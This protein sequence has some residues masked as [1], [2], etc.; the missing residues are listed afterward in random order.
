MAKSNRDNFPDHVRE[1][2]AQ[3]VAYKCSRPGCERVTSGPHSDPRKSLKLGVA[4]HIIA[5]AARGP[6]ASADISSDDRKSI[7]NA[8]WLCTE[9]STLID[10]DESRYP[11]EELR[12]WK[13]EA[14]EAARL[15][16]ER[17]LVDPVS[18]L[19]NPQAFPPHLDVF[20]P[21]TLREAFTGR[22]RQRQSL[23]RWW[24]EDGPPVRVLVGMGGMGKSSLAWVWMH[25]DVLGNRVI[26][27]SATQEQR[28]RGTGL[29]ASERPEG[30][31]WWSFYAPELQIQKSFE[32]FLDRALG[33][34]SGGQIR[35]EN[36][37]SLNEK[38]DV[39]LDRLRSRRFLIILDGFERATKLYDQLTAPYEADLLEREPTSELKRCSDDRAGR[40]L[41][42]AAATSR[43]RV[44]ITSRVHPAD[45]DGL[46]N[47]E[48]HDLEALDPEDSLE[49]FRA[50]RVS[51]SDS[52]I[53]AACSAAGHHPLAVRLMIGYIM[54]TPGQYRGHI[55]ALPETPLDLTPDDRRRHIFE[56]AYNGLG[57]QD[58]EFFSRVAVY[59][60]ATAYHV[61]QACSPFSSSDELDRAIE[62]LEQ[63]GFLSYDREHSTYDMHP[64]VRQY[65]Y[66]QMATTERRQ[67]AREAYA[68]LADRLSEHETTLATLS[69]T[70]EVFGHAMEGGLLESAIKIF[71]H[72]L[73]PILFFRIGHFRALADLLE[74][75]IAR[76]REEQPE[77]VS[78]GNLRALMDRLS[79][80]YNLSGFPR[81]GYR[82]ATEAAT[83]HASDPNAGSEAKRLVYRASSAMR[84]GELQLAT[85]ALEKSILINQQ[86]G[87]RFAET[88]ARLNLGLA[89]TWSARFEEARNHL[90]AAAE[91]MGDTPK[92]RHWRCI[93][94]VHHARAALLMGHGDR[95]L[96][97]ARAAHKIATDGKDETDLVR[98]K[99]V[100][101]ASLVRRVE[102]D[103]A[104]RP[105]YL[106]MAEPHLLSALRTCSE[107]EYGELMM[108][109]HI[110]LA[111][112]HFANGDPAQAQQ[113]AQSARALA[114]EGGHALKKA[115]ADEILLELA[116]LAAAGSIQCGEAAESVN[117]RQADQLLA[118]WSLS[119]MPHVISVEPDPRS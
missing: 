84:L 20:H 65:A 104:L 100:L 26:E 2:V 44:L 15:E 43:S 102:E 70:R 45:V 109:L 73:Y 23:T 10:K 30:V 79:T 60:Q 92:S 115:E 113:A 50:H 9:C 6:R 94:L 31:L 66:T 37:P 64:L 27:R 33:Y 68:Y 38:I 114:Q 75:L 77:Q 19:Q 53:L 119:S 5:A 16:L 54:N 42:E 101:G 108:E 103:P 57:A 36:I 110:A 3:R 49:L 25:E 86:N 111:H 8:I 32:L 14:E 29:C 51:G 117:S 7:E 98:S 63:R 4:A 58:R 80:A 74:Q 55:H 87:A 116:Q 21:H 69:L 112:W 12:R 89:L 48:R 93:C 106:P 1:T 56:V 72:R 97:H 118:V 39:L 95:A 47:V 52:D 40:F 11:V 90:D 62:R 13:A 96:Q 107:M 67:A 81:E 71:L 59:T 46:A 76:V 24:K 35:P 99:W 85:D 105:T 78:S 34:V 61:L 22:A 82:W 41:R 83:L 18:V 88:I 28:K 91:I 17:T